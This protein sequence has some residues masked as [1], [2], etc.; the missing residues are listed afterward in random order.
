MQSIYSI[1]Q[2]MML[3]Y[4]P[5]KKCGAQEFDMTWHGS[6]RSTSPSKSHVGVSRI[7]IEM[8]DDT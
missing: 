2:F 7:S 5:S 4:L 1:K 6:R 8:P 3:F